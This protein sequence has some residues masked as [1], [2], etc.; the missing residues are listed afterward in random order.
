MKFNTVRDAKLRALLRTG[1]ASRG[2]WT[3][4]AESV[5]AN[6]ACVASSPRV[7][8]LARRASLLDAAGRVPWRV[9]R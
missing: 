7:A 2:S 5:F 4:D 9:S 6:G 8:A 3:A 1:S